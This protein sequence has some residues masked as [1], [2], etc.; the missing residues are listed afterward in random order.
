MDEWVETGKWYVV[1]V[2]P[3]IAAEQ[4][5]APPAASKGR[6]DGRFPAVRENDG[7][8]RMLARRNGR[9]APWL[10]LPLAGLLVA[11]PG[12]LVSQDPLGTPARERAEE[13][14]LMVQRRAQL[15]VVLGE[16]VE[17]GSRAGVRVREAVP[18]GPA[19]RA[20][21]E[22]D[23][24]VLALNGQTLGTE[25]GERL[26]ELMRDVAPGDTV[27]LLLHRDGR[28][29]TVRVVTE[30]AAPVSIRLGEMVRPDVLRPQIEGRVAE[31]LAGLGPALG[32]LGPHRLQL[33]AM[34]PGLGR[35]FGVD[36]GVLVADVAPE[37]TLGLQAGDV[38]VSI[39]GRTVQDAAHA[40]SILASYRP[41]E[42]VRME[43]YRD[44]RR[45]TVEGTAGET[46]RFRR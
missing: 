20:G 23:D 33:V 39:G 45:I 13:L 46:R 31:A 21:V 16:R 43:V 25:P 29:R 10:L 24:V 9:G 2:C 41:D 1:R 42:E 37:S 34:N 19:A 17:V 44:R 18:G 14:R 35:Y 27:T 38:I 32:M 7:R 15:G 26:R 28:D 5:S 11:W 6:A 4:P 36:E 3:P 8:K 40:R 12:P 22:A 30:R